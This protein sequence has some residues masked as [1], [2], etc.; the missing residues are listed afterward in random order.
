MFLRKALQEK[1]EKKVEDHAKEFAAG[2][3][4]SLFKSADAGYTGQSLSLKDREDAHIILQ[5][6]FVDALTIALDNCKVRIEN[7]EHT[8]ILFKRKYTTK[9]LHISWRKDDDD[10]DNTTEA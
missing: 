3:M 4:Q 2:I 9:H 5:P 1:T 7:R 8:D 10:A 6:G